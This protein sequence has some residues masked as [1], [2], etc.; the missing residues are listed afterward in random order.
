MFVMETYGLPIA[1][2][3][4]GDQLQRE[5]HASELRLGYL[6]WPR[7]F[8]RQLDGAC[9]LESGANIADSM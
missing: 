4:A 9:P 6:G 1:I 8:L 5:G 7:A 2:P 3:H